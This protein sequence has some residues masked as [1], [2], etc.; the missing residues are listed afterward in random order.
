MRD[1][2]SNHTQINWTSKG[3]T[4]KIATIPTTNKWT[5]RN[6]PK[7]PMTKTNQTITPPTK[8]STNNQQYKT[9]LEALRKEIEALKHNQRRHQ[10]DQPKRHHSAVN[11]LKTIQRTKQNQQNT[12]SHNRSQQRTKETTTI[13]HR[14]TQARKTTQ[15]N[16]K[17]TG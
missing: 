11:Y 5:T 8:I 9:D 15:C 3:N 7:L 4:M 17:T 2:Y 14:T 1:Q 12:L 10:D 13:I 16:V 6:Q